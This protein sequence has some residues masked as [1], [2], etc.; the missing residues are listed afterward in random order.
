MAAHPGCSR[1]PWILAVTVR[2]RNTRLGVPAG[3]ES[4]LET[5]ALGVW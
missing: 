5:D 4:A 3:R 1:R 2:R